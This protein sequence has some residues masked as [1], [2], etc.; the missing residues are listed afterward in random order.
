LVSSV[1]VVAVVAASEIGFLESWT[2]VV[3]GQD[4]III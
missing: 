3:V 2:A 1:V 4:L